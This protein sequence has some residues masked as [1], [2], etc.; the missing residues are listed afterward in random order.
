LA[1]KL[2][3]YAFGQVREIR[4]CLRLSCLELR[5]VQVLM[6]EVVYRRAI[7][8][9]L[10]FFLKEKET[11]VQTS[12]RKAVFFFTFFL[13]KK[14][15]KSQGGTMRNN[16]SVRSFPITNRRL[17]EPFRLTSFNSVTMLLVVGILI[18]RRT[19]HP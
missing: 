17:K 14:V 3:K 16:R 11:K 4:W 9:L 13:T 15:T 12:P 7:F 19:L 18:I 1:V 6:F 10:L 2:G 5:F 8:L